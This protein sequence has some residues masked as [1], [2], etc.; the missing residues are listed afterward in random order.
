M[1]RRKVIIPIDSVLDLFKSYTAE[2]NEIPVDARPVT[3]MLKPQE[4]GKFAII[5]A[6]PEWTKELPPLEIKFDIQRVFQA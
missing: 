2:N 1:A 6:S 3:L 4:T 5:A